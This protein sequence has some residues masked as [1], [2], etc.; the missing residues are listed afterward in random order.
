M[1]KYGC[2]RPATKA[3]GIVTSR[4]SWQGTLPFGDV[5]GREIRNLSIEV[6]LVFWGVTSL[7]IPKTHTSPQLLEA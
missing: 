1:V 2:T 3:Q 4:Q 5:I 6:K 7:F